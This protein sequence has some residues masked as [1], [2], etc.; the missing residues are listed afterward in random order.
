MEL[1]ELRKIEHL[2]A[3][4]ISDYIDCGL[5]YK[6]GRIDRIQPEFKSDALEFGS[7]THLALADFHMEKLRG[8]FPALKELQ[9]SFEYHWRKLTDGRDDIKYAEAENGR[10]SPGIHVPRSRQ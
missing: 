10:E 5:L 6:F 4:S 7:A 2:S 1:Q 3:S 9:Q 8:R